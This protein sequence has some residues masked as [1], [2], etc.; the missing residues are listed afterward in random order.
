MND[1][2][3]EKILKR[4]T[5]SPRDIMTR[6]ITGNPIKYEGYRIFVCGQS[7]YVMMWNIIDAV[8][9]QEDYQGGTTVYISPYDDKVIEK[10]ESAIDEC[11]VVILLDLSPCVGHLGPITHLDT[12]YKGPIDIRHKNVC[13]V[14]YR[15]TSCSEE[16]ERLSIVT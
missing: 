6:E 3:R 1:E 13:F 11:Q 9:S 14:S 12:V 16:W 15:C 5:V 10:D 8:T 7:C 4:N 2:Q